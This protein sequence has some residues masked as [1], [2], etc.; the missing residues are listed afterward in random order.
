VALEQA[1]GGSLN[2]LIKKIKD[3]FPD[4]NFD[5]PPEPDTKCKSQY[6]CKGLR[7]ITYSDK[8]GNIYCGRRYKL[9]DDNNPHAWSFKEC[10]ALLQKKRQGGIQDEIPF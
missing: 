2:D 5:I 10:H 6:D 9:Q 1:G 7:N 8:E 3:R 4:Y